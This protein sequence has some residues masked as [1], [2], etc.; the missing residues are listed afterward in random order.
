MGE[1]IGKDQQNL[2]RKSPLEILL[3]F[4]EYVGKAFPPKA[5]TDMLVTVLIHG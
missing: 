2:R 3:K 4:A 5:D 1:T